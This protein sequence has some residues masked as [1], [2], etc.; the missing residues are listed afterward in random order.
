MSHLVG[1]VAVG[2]LADLVLWK[3]ENFGSKPEM[4]LK[5]GV[6]VVAPMGDPNASIP[7][8]QPI[9]TRPMWG[10]KAASAAL[11][12][13][14]FVSQASLNSG[15][16]ASYNLSKRFEAVRDC[17]SVTKKDMKWNNTI[18]KMT[19]DPESYEVRADG[20]LQDIQAAEKLPLTRAYN[21]F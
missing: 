21:L 15:M 17:R 18:P 20:I 1:H 2:T 12:S 14:S 16:V 13:V 11:N 3:P 9:Y 4:V 6:I 8:I 7:T 10:S 19:V 5:S